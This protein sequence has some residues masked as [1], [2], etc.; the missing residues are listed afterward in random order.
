M[1]FGLFRTGADA[2]YVRHCACADCSRGADAELSPGGGGAAQ[3]PGG[4][5]K[6]GGNPYIDALIWGN[7]WGGG[8][9]VAI[10]Y[11]FVDSH[12]AWTAAEKAAMAAALSTW[13]D[14]AAVTFHEDGSGGGN[15]KFHS[16]DA[17]YFQTAG[18][19]GRQYGP[20]GTS[21]AGKG[22]YNR[23]GTGWTMA[24]RAQGGFGF[25]T[26]IHEIG[27]A[28]GLAHP[29]HTSGVSGLFPG[30]AYGD[31]AS[32]GT[33]G[34]NQGVFTTMSYNDGLASDRH[35]PRVSVAYG[36]QGTP[37][38]F[39][40]AAIQ[41]IYGANT[42][43]AAGNDTYALP[44]ANAAGTFYRCIWDAGGYDRI[45]YGGARDAVIDLRPAPLAG[46]DA[47]GH[48][49]RAAGVVGGFT[50]A[51][52]V[53][54]EAAEG[55]SGNDRLIGNDADN[56]LN[57]GGGSDTLTGGAGRDSFLVGD[58]D[59][60]TD[61]TPED[62]I[63]VAGYSTA[64]TI[65]AAAGAGLTAV[66]VSEGGRSL[67][68]RLTGTGFTAAGFSRTA[69]GDSLRLTHGATI[70]ALPPAPLPV[71]FIAG[72]SVLLPPGAT[73]TAAVEPTAGARD[74]TTAILAGTVA[75][76]GGG[77]TMAAAVDAYAARFAPDAGLTLRTVTGGG[78]AT[79][80][81]MVILAGGGPG[82]ALVLDAR[83]M[84]AGSL[85]DVEGVG[86]VAVL[87]DISVTTGAPAEVAAGDDG[88]QV[89][90]MGGGDDTAYG[91]GGDDVLYGNP[92]D[93]RLYGNVGMDTLFG[94]QGADG[95][96]GGQDDD[97]LFGQLGDDVLF[98]QL[99]NDVLF[100]G[101]GAD[102]LFGGQGGDA[103]FGNR[104]ADLLYGNLGDDTLDGG[105]G[106]DTLY[107]GAGA[108]L[109]R[110]T[111]PTDGGDT[112]ADF[113]PG[114]DRI[115]VVGPNFGLVHAGPLAPSHFALDNPADGDDL[116]VFDTATGVLA[117]DADGVGPGA[118]VTIATLNVRTLSAGD[119]MVL[120]S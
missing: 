14:V 36:Y 57:G 73:L 35:S 119:I 77:G 46:P 76:L 91:G 40:V 110:F 104:G 82:E 13:S 2:G 41:H 51:N 32:L 7:R 27:H 54:I 58:D 20:D 69:A 72:L 15:L 71:S 6:T 98:G 88:A 94:G 22:W 11:S 18:T 84:A 29:H 24:G 62:D 74:R 95:L 55:G 12:Y 79:D 23:Q 42:G 5:G 96:F 120:A 101:Q 52:G 53:I 65:T 68:F 115:A 102:T 87:G 80:R 26:L 8:A 9:P 85:V 59:L 106:A 118:A 99:G 109:F 89:L 47:G 28:L 49:S 92:G 4:A 43:H 103:L 70:G 34:Q 60:I 64:A 78:A 107:G 113:E 3:W 75:G 111:A 112:V 66:T 81:P 39:D 114:V 10:T 16:V 116:F 61:L 56:R 93:D 17:A 33:D 25:V 105:E 86:F 67:T 19:L 97:H 100:G 108:D 90:A 45:V 30:V 63:Y 50:I 31:H 83:A 1:V 44:D 38:A 48:I 21:G 117:F 37:M